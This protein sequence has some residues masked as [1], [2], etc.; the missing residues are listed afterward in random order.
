MKPHGI[1]AL[2]LAVVAAF[3]ALPHAAFAA[4]QPDKWVSYVESTGNQ[5]VDTG[6]TGRWNTKIEAKVEWMDVSSEASFL[7]ARSGAL[8]EANADGCMYFCYCLNANG[9]MATA[10]DACKNVYLMSKGNQWNWRWE[11]NRVYTY[12]S[13]FTVTNAA[14]KTTS[15]ITADGNTAST[16][17]FTGIDT[18]YNLYLFANNQKGNAD[19]KA[20]ARCYGLKIWQ[21]PKD[22]GDMV[23]VRDFQPCMNGGRA[24]LYDAVSKTIF[25]SGSGTDLI[26]DENS[27]V[28]DEFI[29]YVESSGDAAEKDSQI[30]SYIDTGVIGRSGTKVEGEFAILKHEDAGLLGSRNN[31]L[32]NPR[33]YLLQSYNSKIT[34][35][36]G[37]HKDNS[38]TL[39]LGKKYWVSTELNAGSQLEQ[40]GADGTTKT[41]YSASD[42]VSINTGYTVYLFSCNVEGAPT[43]F[44]KARCYGFKVW[45][46]GAL[47][48]DFRPCLKNGVAG[49]YD[50]VSK[51]IF[52]SLGTPLSY[53]TRKKAKAKE[54]VFVE[55]IESDGNNT[56]DTGVPARSGTRAKG[57]MTWV[58][59][60]DYGNG[61]LRTWNHENYRY[62]ENT[63][64][65][66]VWYR[67][68]RS[69]LGAVD[70]KNDKRFFMVYESNSDLETVYGS[71][72]LALP[73]GVD[74][75]LSYLYHGRKCSFD[76][77]FAAGSQTVE[78]DGT[79]V[80]SGSVADAV[81]TGDTLHIFS[82]SQWRHRS[83]ARCYGLQIWQDGNLV[84]DFKPCLVD[85][86]GMLYDMVTETLYRP[87]P[88]IPAS[89]V[90]KVV[91]SGEEKPAQYIDYVESDGTIFVDTGIVGKSGTAADLKMQ[92]KEKADVGFLESRKGN[93]R[94]YLWHNNT[95]NNTAIYGYDGFSTALSNAAVGVDYTVSSSLSVGSQTITVNGTQTVNATDNKTID[96]GYN[97][98]L[99]TCHYDGKPQYNGKARLYWLKL[100]QGD[101]DGSNMQLVRN[102]KPVRLSNGL[103]VLWDFVEKKAYRP[104]STT[105]PYDYTT[106]PIVGP[107]GAA[108]RDG[109]MII[110]R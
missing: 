106:F 5:W 91:L 35:G 67:Q 70:V 20:K 49:L 76:V 38:N 51:R 12:T 29:E 34:C 22:G 72:T 96:T 55:Y 54:I 17:E 102:F 77:T 84:R 2:S 7:G 100:Y 110:V 80:R 30:P 97:L 63:A 24:G 43:W 69:Y 13:E 101:A 28:P 85:G 62:L 107:D 68:K 66:G 19:G 26:C 32:S 50:D 82:S 75:T 4:A 83:A 53:D 36:Y 25:Y 109:L 74:K 60:G 99:F 9:E 48:R 23:L 61:Y 16:I 6:I 42:A 3:A 14:G 81:D 78:W 47:V 58:T 46:D 103:V 44:S 64:A 10:S 11:L 88:D 39:E 104:Q 90:G 21:G 105:A 108:I 37:T 40:I 92:F 89:R 94:Y 52:Y 27:E 41:V 31:K 57:D 79:V 33:F 56:L 45:Q 87:S 86:K 8:G 15:K 59:P 18:G 1:H 65:P 98:C 95:K 71:T 93:T 73:A